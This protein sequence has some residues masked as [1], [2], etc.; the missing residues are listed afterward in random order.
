MRSL[1]MVFFLLLGCGDVSVNERAELE[2]DDSGECSN[3]ADDDGDGL[4]DCADPDCAG[5]AV[6][7]GDDDDS[8][9]SD[10]DDAGPDDDDSA[11]DDDDDSGAPD[12][13]DA[14]DDDDSAEPCTGPNTGSLSFDGV[15]DYVALGTLPTFDDTSEFTVELWARFSTASSTGIPG[16][17]L[18]FHRAACPQQNPVPDP[19]GMRIWRDSPA[20]VRFDFYDAEGGNQDWPVPVVLVDDGWHHLALTFDASTRRAFLDGVQVGEQANLSAESGVVTSI[21]AEIGRYAGCG[22]AGMSFTGNVDELRIWD[23]ART[24]KELQAELTC[25]LSGGESGLLG[26]WDFEQGGGQVLSDLLGN[27]DG[28]L[29]DGAQADDADPTWSPLTPW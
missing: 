7:A 12:D 8:S 20:N 15:D 19:T 6:C 3:D 14:G 17:G 5:A 16:Y 26:Y 13:D 28:R 25:P 9:L 1:P 27:S 23:H 24:S 11:A 18:L 21:E 10:D 22:P 2:G 4:F 29:G